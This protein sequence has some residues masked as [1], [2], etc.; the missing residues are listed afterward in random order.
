M[1]FGVYKAMWMGMKATCIA[2][3]ENLIKIAGKVDQNH[4]KWA[5]DI[6]NAVSKSKEQ[7]LTKSAFK[8]SASLEQLHKAMLTAT[9][10][11]F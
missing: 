10:A 4:Q 2:L 1:L 5:D 9:Q 8:F 6:V 3:A 11:Y 7:D